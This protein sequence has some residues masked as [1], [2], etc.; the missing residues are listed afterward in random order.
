[1]IK[2]RLA[3]LLQK[4]MQK[5]TPLEGESA[6]EITAEVVAENA[7]PD[8]SEP[9]ADTTATKRTSPT[10]MDLEATVEELRDNLA[11]A[12][13]KEASFQQQISNLKSALSEQESSGERL[14]KE[15]DETK[16][17]ALQLAEANSQLIEEINN[18]KQAK[19][20]VNALVKEPIKE[21]YNSLSYRKSHRSTERLQE[22]PTGS[23]ENFADNTWL[24]D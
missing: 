3:D 16:K 18:L 10:K 7:S 1:M 11:Q 13:K 4:E 9:T 5:F 14:A 19:E 15:L 12:Q 23:N 24:Y 17:T 2:K 6:I 8:A 20:P 21:A 22:R